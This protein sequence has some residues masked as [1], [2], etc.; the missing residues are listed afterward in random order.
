MLD[1]IAQLAPA[2]ATLVAM[3]MLTL[4][5]WLAGRIVLTSG[6]LRRPWPDLRSIDLPQ[7]AMLVLAAALAL[8]FVGGLVGMLSQMVSA[9]L[10]HG[11]HCSSA[12]PCCMSSPNRP[13]DVLVADRRLRRGRHLLVWPL[14]LV[15]MLGLL[16]GAARPAP[17][18]RQQRQAHPPFHPDNQPHPTKRRTIMEVI[19]LERVAKLGQMGEVVRVRDGFARNFLLPRGKALRATKDNR[20]KFD[21]MKAELEARNLKAKGEAEKAATRIDGRDVVVLRQAS[22]TGALYGS[23]SSRDLVTLFEAEGIKVTRGQIMLDAPL[24]TI[25]KHKIEI[26]VHPEVE[27]TVTVT[28]ARN[29]DEAER[30]KR[31]ENVTVRREEQD[32]AAEAL[33][34]AEEFFDPEARKEDEGE[35]RR[36]D[37]RQAGLIADDLREPKTTKAL[38]SAS[39]F[40]FCEPC[41]AAAT[42]AARASFAGLCAAG[43]AHAPLPA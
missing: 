8:S 38:V 20:E 29:A 11:L 10:L 37:R 9:A 13:P 15:L 34:A 18:F 31:G 4:N 39:A 27:V 5:L 21:G 42:A 41:D 12:L 32:E 23:V 36:G 35:S 26:A 28:V 7:T 16:D 6:R 14:L 2:A 24:K 19:L 22:D 40:C 3:L 33:A 43:A 17:A 1:A 30:I 25:G